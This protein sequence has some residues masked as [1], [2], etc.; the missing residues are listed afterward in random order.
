[1]T[2]PGENGCSEC[3]RE[4][5]ADGMDLVVEAARDSEG[6]SRVVGQLHELR[7]SGNSKKRTRF[8]DLEE[9][10]EQLAAY[11]RLEAPREMNQ[12][13]GPLWEVKTANDRVPFYFRSVM[14]AHRRAARLTHHF[15][16]AT[17]RTAE[18]RTPRKHI[19]R[20]NWIM[21]GDQN[22]G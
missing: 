19:D 13:D 10:F 21:K 7:D 16:K 4:I 9:R 14:A 6:N 18:G 3:L 22:D 11:G 5:F 15:P 12:L 17:G 2:V 1:M 8:Y 20:G